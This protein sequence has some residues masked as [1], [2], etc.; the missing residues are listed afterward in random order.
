MK[1]LKLNT[2]L[3]TVLVELRALRQEIRSAGKRLLPIP[4]AADYL[5]ISP[6]TIRNELSRKTF[7]V[8]AVRHGGKVLFRR[9]DLDAYIESLGAE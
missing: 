5:G 1:S 8:R 6:R 7:P 2:D 3:Q 9:Q 4:E